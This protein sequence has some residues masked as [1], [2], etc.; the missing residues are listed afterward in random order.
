MKTSHENNTSDNYAFQEIGKLSSGR[1]STSPLKSV[2]T[3]MGGAFY[4]KANKAKNGAE[5]RLYAPDDPNMIATYD[6]N[7]SHTGAIQNLGM[8]VGMDLPAHKV[9]KWGRSYK[10]KIWGRSRK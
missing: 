1:R 7:V 4:T 2:A 6:G 10:V 5:Q 3:K 9:K 8:D